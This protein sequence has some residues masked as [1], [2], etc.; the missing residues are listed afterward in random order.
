MGAT[1]SEVRLFNGDCLEEMRKLVEAGVQ[2]DAVVCD[3]PYGLSDHGDITPFLAAWI[4]GE[5]VE[6]KK[7]GFMGKAWDGFVPG[8]E[9][10]RLCHQL[11]KPG[12]HLV[13][14]AGARTSD[15]MGIAVRLAG[16]EVRDVVSYL[17]AFGSGFPKSHDVSKAIDKAVG[18]ERE[19]IGIAADFARDGA[20]RDAKRHNQ[21]RAV[22][23]IGDDGG[24]WSRPI[25]APSSAP[26]K[27][28]EGWGTA[29]KPAY[30]PILLARKP[31]SGTV[32]ANVLEH[33]TGAINIGGCRVG[34]TGARNNGRKASADYGKSEDGS[35]KFGDFGA[36]TRV[37]Y[38]MGRWPAN[39]CH[40]GSPEIA[41][42]FS[43]FRGEMAE[44]A[45]S[46]ADYFPSL[47][48]DAEDEELQRFFYC[49]KATA[50]DRDEGLDDLE[51]KA[52][53]LQHG[54]IGRQCSV[55]KRKEAEGVNAPTR[56]NVHPT[57]KPTALMRWLCRLV[58]PSG[59]TILDPFMGSGS[60]GKAA[61]LE[62]FSFVGIER[63]AEYME[64]AQRRIAWA[65]EQAER[66]KVVPAAEGAPADAEM[67]EEE[68]TR[69]A[70]IIQAVREMREEA[71]AN[72]VVLGSVTSCAIDG[73]TAVVMVVPPD[74]TPP[75][76]KSK[77]TT[78]PEVDDRQMSLFDIQA[79]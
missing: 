29:L 35:Q 60:T 74:N 3:P 10:W 17:W 67:S 33:G 47:G 48:P 59:G 4:A 28:W 76:P 22:T 42:K 16:F 64:I 49:G 73:G 21:T 57:V 23:I 79:A 45:P 70:A 52:S 53:D 19:V 58:T 31:L 8:P 24:G 50:R 43:G 13:A 25:T 2:V 32:A 11:L 61:V 20:K 72:G 56:R 30:E 55:E 66:P 65:Q 1:G 51:A 75:S 69:V 14:F 40:D 54:N 39:L 71:A 77:K 36:T 63:E 78:K 46:P 68:A 5:A 26:A 27:E 37:D 41:A 44:K 7:K 12:G 6:V 38:G 9:Y 15:L 18:A 62:G 34:E